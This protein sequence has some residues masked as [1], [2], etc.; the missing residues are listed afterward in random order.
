MIDLRI[1][2][3]FKFLFYVAKIVIRVYAAFCVK[4]TEVG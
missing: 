2:D 1:R 4:Q 3:Q